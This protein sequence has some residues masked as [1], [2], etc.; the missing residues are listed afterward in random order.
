MAD[1]FETSLTDLRAT[2]TNIISQKT[3]RRYG[4][5]E[6]DNALE[7]AYV[8]ICGKAN[9]SFLKK[10]DTSIAITAGSNTFSVPSDLL[11]FDPR[12][13][14]L[15]LD[16]KRLG[17]KLEYITPNLRDNIDETS[18]GQPYGWYKEGATGYL[19][20]KADK[21]YTGILEYYQRPKKLSEEI[22]IPAEYADIIAWW[23]A[24]A[25]ISPTNRN[26]PVIETE[27]INQINELIDAYDVQNADNQQEFIDINDSD[28]I[29]MM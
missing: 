28:S 13:Q 23:G 3:T 20:C 7:K 8:K 10:R 12:T 25:L 4:L 9:F 16:S 29:C 17:N 2:L 15:F 21:G 26:R 1:Y 22:L 27:C 14:G 24:L 6:R 19:S 11:R 5:S 18:S